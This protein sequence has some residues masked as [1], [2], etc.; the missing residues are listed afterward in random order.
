[1]KD[2]SYI[3][4]IRLMQQEFEGFADFLASYT[5][6]FTHVATI[7]SYGIQLLGN[8]LKKRKYTVQELPQQD[9]RFL[10]F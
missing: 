6:S 4:A 7:A 9:F 1:M 2:F 5:S 8:N 3:L 10:Y